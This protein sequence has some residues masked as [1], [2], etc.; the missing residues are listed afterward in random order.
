MDLLACVEKGK[1]VVLPAKTGHLIQVE[2]GPPKQEA[3]WVGSHA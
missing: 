1:R 2:S 3:T